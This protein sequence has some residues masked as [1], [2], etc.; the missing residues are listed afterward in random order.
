MKIKFNWGTGIFIAIVMFMIFILSFV[1][2][3]IAIDKYQHE[4]VSEDYYKDELHYQ[5]DIDKLNN[6]AKLDQNIALNNSEKGITIIFPDDMDFKQIKGKI[7]FQKLSNKKLD[8]TKD[9]TLESHRFLIPDSV[10]VPGKWVIRI[11]WNYNGEE[12]LLKEDWFY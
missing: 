1:Y 7:I 12:Y 11:D 10:L 4:L 8:F 5:Q 2:K 6:A 3:S 9:I